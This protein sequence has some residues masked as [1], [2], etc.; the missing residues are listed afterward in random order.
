MSR[1]SEAVT[2][3]VRVEG[4]WEF[5]LGD[6]P[7][8]PDPCLMDIDS[9]RGLE[10]VNVYRMDDALEQQVIPYLRALPPC[11]KKHRLHGYATY[12][13]LLIARMEHQ[14]SEDSFHASIYLAEP[15]PFVRD[16]EIAR[17]RKRDLKRY[18][19]QLS[20][21]KSMKQFMDRFVVLPPYYEEMP[22]SKTVR[23]PLQ[24]RLKEIA[25]YHGT[26]L[27]HENRLY[28]IASHSPSTLTFYESGGYVKTIG[29]AFERRIY[30]IAFNE[31]EYF[32]PLS[33]PRSCEFDPDGLKESELNQIALKLF[34]HQRRG[35]T[36]M[37]YRE[38]RKFQFNSM[39][40][41]VC[42][43]TYL[44]DQVFYRPSS[45]LSGD[46]SVE[47]SGGILADPLRMGKTVV[48]LAL[49]ALDPPLSLD[50]QDM[51]VETPDS[52]ASLVFAPDHLAEQWFE[53]IGRVAPQMA[54]QS[55][56]LQSA[57]DLEHLTVRQ[58]LEARVIITTY[59]FMC[60]EAMIRWIVPEGSYRCTTQ[61]L[62]NRWVDYNRVIAET[63]KDWRDVR[64]EFMGLG[65][66]RFRRVILDEFHEWAQMKLRENAK[67]FGF[68]FIHA[69]Q[70]RYRWLVSG[71]P[72][73]GQKV[74]YPLLV[75]NI[76]MN[77]WL[78]FTPIQR[79]FATFVRREARS[80]LRFPKVNY[81][82]ARVT[83]TG[84]ERAL[85]D[86][87]STDLSPEDVLRLCT[88][89]D[90]DE[91]TRRFLSTDKGVTIDEVI[92][93]T[94]RRLTHEIQE[95]RQQLVTAETDDQKEWIERMLI[96]KSVTQVIMQTRIQEL[97]SPDILQKEACAICR[98]EMQPGAEVSILPCAHIFCQSCT[99]RLQRC[100]I[101]RREFDRSSVLTKV[102]DPAAK[103][104]RLE[105][106]HL[107]AETRYGSKLDQVL[108]VIQKLTSRKIIVFV[109]WNDILDRIR[110]IFAQ[111]QIQSIV[112]RGSGEEKQYALRE[113]RTN[114]Q[115][116]VVF[117]SPT[118]HA[119]G[120]NMVNADVVCFVHPISYW[121]DNEVVAKAYEQQAIG[122]TQAPGLEKEVDVYRF[123]TT[124][125]IEATFPLIEY[126]ANS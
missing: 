88:Y 23:V 67:F 13:D 101:C 110:E 103:R 30:G 117:L 113:F 119:S 58:L 90:V 115:I 38:T 61:A 25:F 34:P 63:H 122:R 79:F 29:E 66:I 126:D 86:S 73:A 5:A 10:A 32:D 16:Y 18:N 77:W 105:I 8:L 62:R 121:M 65:Q 68:Q 94:L 102:V 35:I 21:A 78:Q 31:D 41:H 2:S 26:L 64:L 27:R 47:I 71:T 95:L 111:H 96:E 109:Q 7:E 89:F 33:H 69:V 36:W 44:T 114:P 1:F 46:V 48:I 99:K 92:D 49:C 9:S 3:Y 52:Q 4:Y 125:T 45:E 17:G 42:G 24:H 118:L 56:L 12:H 60:S 80:Q 91:H 116:Q 108:S 106:R 40:V 84:K 53:E 98:E 104:R 82:V 100:A 120:T 112:V 37:R 6:I 72:E 14:F 70:S 55:L 97:D 124:D 19:L 81:H 75:G 123:I 59:Q 54:Q 28:Y 20:T 11:I 15:L 50:Y 43:Q 74:L 107:P 83:L 76:E 22:R 85:Y 39:L 51:S 57:K 93:S 87:L